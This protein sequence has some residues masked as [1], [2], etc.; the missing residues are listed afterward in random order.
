MTEAMTAPDTRNIK[1][2]TRPIPPTGRI[3]I[4]SHMLPGI[5]DG[6]TDIDESIASI[7]QLKQAGYA[8]TICTPHLWPE[9]FPDNTP[10]NIRRWTADLSQKLAE[11]GVDY[12][13]WPGGELRLFDDCVDWLKKVGVP[14][15]GGSKYVLCDFWEDAWPKYADTLFDWLMSEGYQPI[16]AHPERIGVKDGLEKHLDAV[17]ARG[18]LLQGNFRCMTGED[19]FLPDQRVRQYLAE[20]RY[21]IMALDMHRPADLPDRMDGMRMVAEEFGQDVVDHMTIDRPR[22]ILIA[23]EK[24]R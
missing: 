2:D 20:G 14:T 6:C 21:W 1:P 23:T 9:L 8:G 16:L 22:E 17:T 11:R 10:A 24:V 13:L 3:D 18:V 19:G 4:H 7:T 5:D 15:L 12:P